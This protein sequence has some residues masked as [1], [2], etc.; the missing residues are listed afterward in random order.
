MTLFNISELKKIMIF[1]NILYNGKLSVMI[2]PIE[3]KVAYYH[4]DVMKK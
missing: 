3:I 2:F 1:F 4:L